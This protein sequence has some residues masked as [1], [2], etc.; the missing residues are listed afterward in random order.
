MRKPRTSYY[1]FCYFSYFLVGRPD[2]EKESAFH[3]KNKIEI[4]IQKP[5][6]FVLLNLLNSYYINSYS[7]LKSYMKIPIKIL[8]SYFLVGLSDFTKFV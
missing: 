5:Y 8:F 4:G 6:I 2:F 1:S 3:R 7:L